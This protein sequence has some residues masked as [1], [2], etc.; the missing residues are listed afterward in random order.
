MNIVHALFTKKLEE[1]GI[2]E[3][4]KRRGVKEGDTV[5]LLDWEFEWY[6]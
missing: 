1:T 3:E 4:L 2:F 5:K 6:E